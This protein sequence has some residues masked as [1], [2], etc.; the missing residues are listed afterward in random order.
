MLLSLLW[1]SALNPV[2]KL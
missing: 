1:I 2:L